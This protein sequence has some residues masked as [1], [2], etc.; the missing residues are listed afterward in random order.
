MRPKLKY[1]R[2]KT[3]EG[4]KSGTYHPADVQTF[5]DPTPLVAEEMLDKLDHSFHN[6]F[7]FLDLGSGADQID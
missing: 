3:R 1:L 7:V 4:V 6:A 2:G 5:I